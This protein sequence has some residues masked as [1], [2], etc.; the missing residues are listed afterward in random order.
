MAVAQ[1]VQ[2]VTATESES[3]QC[4]KALV[5]LSVHTV[6]HTRGL[7]GEDAFLLRN[8][9]AGLNNMHELKV[10]A[11]GCG[12]GAGCVA[13]SSSALCSCLRASETD[14]VCLASTQLRA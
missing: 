7:F 14:S 1:A 5:R 13:R 9:F 11:L 2:V 4:V 8:G 10:R 6:C 3:M 12:R